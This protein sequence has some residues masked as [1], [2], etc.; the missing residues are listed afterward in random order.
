MDKVN[1]SNAALFVR[2]QVFQG[3][4]LA[5]FDDVVQDSILLFQNNFS[6]DHTDIR[7]GSTQCFGRNSQKIIPRKGNCPAIFAQ[8]KAAVAHST[9]I[10]GRT[11]IAFRRNGST[12]PKGKPGDRHLFA[13][14]CRAGDC[15]I[16][17]D[18]AHLRNG[19][20]LVFH[21]AYLTVRFV[22]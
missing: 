9:H 6:I 3:C 14:V 7:A 11:V 21:A 5:C 4:G 19:K 17:T 2:N 13:K 8:D 15:H 18:G 10:Q 16:I 22:G 20:R 1:I 12:R